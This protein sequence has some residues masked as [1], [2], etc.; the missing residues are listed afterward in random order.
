M[1]AKAAENVWSLE[2]VRGKEA[3]RRFPLNGGSI[4]L[5]NA[6]GGEHGI[7]LA[8]QEGSSPRRM[9]AKQAQ[10]ECTAQG[11]MLRDLDSPGGTF[12]NR[13]R[14]LP[15]QARALRP[16]D[17][18]QLAGVQLKVVAGAAAK[19][20]ETSPP[21]SS[22]PPP[23][24]PTATRPR[25][26]PAVFSLAAGAACRT[27]DDF[28]TVAAQRWPAL[29]EE[30]TTGR[31]AAYLTTIG[32]TDL[33]P[34]P[35]A[36]G[37]PDERLDAWLT[38][39][40]TTRPGQPEL[41]VHPETLIVR[42][43]PGGGVARQTIQV[44]NTGYRLLRS[45]VRVEPA[46][47]SWI[48]IA[49][50]LARASFV[51]VERTDL[52]IEVMMP[53]TLDA[54]MLAA[55]VIESNG[56]TRRVEV[57]L[58][59]PP[60][61]DAIPEA[62]PQPPPQLSLG[63]RELIAK[64]PAGTRLILGSAAAAGLRLLIAA[65][66]IFGSEEPAPAIRGAA[67]LLAV[68][69]GMLAATLALR[70]GESRDLLP[71]SFAGAFAGVLLAALVVAACRAIEPTLGHGLVGTTLVLVAL[72]AVLGAALAGLSAWLIPYRPSGGVSP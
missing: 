7:D 21:S 63:L 65:G 4:V 13:Q 43:L 3:G 1:T 68:L 17:L 55:L 47:T 20:V 23:P 52:P 27:W 66:G 62:G 59:K 29:R 60:A 16:D 26:L 72:W 40:P 35:Q 24:R 39:L 71:S 45:T 22:T 12:V 25:E 49:P 54:P 28:L 67:I 19:P 44:A 11:P 42:S 6:L 48:K 10:I 50:E 46:G 34:S 32:R 15:G 53:E 8:E 5:G 18:I 36:P 61:R 2:V 70:R 38:R 51:T 64:Q 69:G 56:G 9:A 57:R 41:D 37:T 58:E 33:I 14:I 31:L 30:L